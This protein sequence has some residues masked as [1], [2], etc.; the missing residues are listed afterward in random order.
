MIEHRRISIDNL[1]GWIELLDLDRDWDWHHRGVG[2]I[3]DIIIDVYG[4]FAG[5]NPA[6]AYDF[7]AK[8]TFWAQVDISL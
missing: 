2:K 8:R 6:D 1:N 7:L 3:F 4:V 5:D